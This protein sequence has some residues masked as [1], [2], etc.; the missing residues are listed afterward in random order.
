MAKKKNIIVPK[1]ENTAEDNRIFEEGKRLRALA[2]EELIPMLK[3][4][5][6]KKIA[7][8]YSWKVVDLK[9]RVLTKNHQDDKRN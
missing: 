4:L 3:E 7:Q 2:R 9:T 8:G 6:R 1:K 5:E